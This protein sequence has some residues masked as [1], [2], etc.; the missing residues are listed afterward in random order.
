MN[1]IKSTGLTVGP[2]RTIADTGVESPRGL[3][4]DWLAGLLFYSS[5]RPSGDQIII[6]NLRGEYTSQ[7]YG[8]H[9]G[10]MNISSL[11]VDPVR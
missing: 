7:I 8:E 2:A 11:A 3:A 10:L 1:E 6:S 4:L 5:S 9:D